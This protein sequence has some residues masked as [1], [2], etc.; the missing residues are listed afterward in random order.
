MAPGVIFAALFVAGSLLIGDL[1]GSYGDP[2]AQFADLHASAA[3]RA[4]Y[5]VGGYLMAAAGIAFIWFIVPL[6]HR[7]DSADAHTPIVGMAR[8]SG[9]I[10]V[11]MLLA[12]AASF[13][14]VAGSM[15]FGELLGDDGQFASAKAALPQLGYAL[16]FVGGML[17]ASSTIAA[18]SLLI[19][20]NRRSY[21][22]LRR[23]G[24][25]SALLLPA[26]VIMTAFL[27]LLPLW[28]LA[29]DLV[30][31]RHSDHVATE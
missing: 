9:A 6:T 15:T 16:F 8:I 21:I 26:S 2:D 17:A 29:A 30:I 10:F 22:L 28:I 18:L 24:Y 23:G 12:S 3:N 5:I 14:A 1:T 20:E 13:M 19:R 4:R 11:A 31:M 25:A 27:V 7:L